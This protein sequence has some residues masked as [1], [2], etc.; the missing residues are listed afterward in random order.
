MYYEKFEQESNVGGKYRWR[1]WA[2]GRIIFQ[3]SE[4]YHNA[5]DRDRS[6]AIS[7]STNE[8]TPVIEGTLNAL[9]KA[10][11]KH[12]IMGV[13]STKE[14]NLLTSALQAGISKKVGF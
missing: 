9:S 10:I 14:V 12:G 13:Q 3:S 1:F 7:M 4:G 2:N 5:E 11:M 6:L 8:S